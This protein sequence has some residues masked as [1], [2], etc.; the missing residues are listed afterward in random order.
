M[1]SCKKHGKYCMNYHNLKNQKK[2]QLTLVS[3]T[4]PS[5]LLLSKILKNSDVIIN[6]GKAVHKLT[7][8]IKYAK[9]MAD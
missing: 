1:V 6:G 4:R 7:D 8:P 9:D 5:G 2:K 3:L